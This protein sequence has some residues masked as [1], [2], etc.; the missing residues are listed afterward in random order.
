[1]I[2]CKLLTHKLMMIFQVT[3]ST[4]SRDQHRRRKNPHFVGLFTRCTLNALSPPQP[5]RLIDTSLL[6]FAIL[7]L[8][9]RATTTTSPNEQITKPILISVAKLVEFTIF[10]NNIQ[11]PL[12]RQRQPLCV[13]TSTI[14]KSSPLQRSMRLSNNKE[15]NFRAHT[16]THRRTDARTS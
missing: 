9:T 14:D 1:M 16:Y 12:Q 6:N 8:N 5:Q 10:D 2:F 4:K 7:Q 15:L 3:R 11:Q 13:Y